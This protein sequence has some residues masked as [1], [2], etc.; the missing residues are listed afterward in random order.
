MGRRIKTEA[1]AKVVP[2]REEFIQFHTVLAVL[3]R[4]ILIIG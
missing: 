2:P 4:T 1:K 3:P